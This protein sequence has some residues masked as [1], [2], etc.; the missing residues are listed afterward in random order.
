VNDRTLLDPVRDSGVEKHL[1]GVG[2]DV[3]RA[4]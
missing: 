3:A 4:P 2:Y 1:L